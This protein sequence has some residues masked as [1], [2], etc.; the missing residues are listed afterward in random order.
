[1]PGI[2]GIIAKR[3]V[4]SAASLIDKMVKTIARGPASSSGTYL[5]AAT[6]LGIGWA[7][8]K[9][10][11]GDC[12]PAWNG[13]KDL[14][15]FFAGENFADAG[16]IEALGAKGA[17]LRA[18]GAGYLPYLVERR[19]EN[20]AENLNGF[21]SGLVLDVSQN[22][23]VLFNDRYGLGRIY[24]H[25]NADAFFFASEAKALLS[26]LPAIRQLDPTGFSEFLTCGC[27]LQ[28]RTLYKD[29]FLAPPASK[30]TFSKG[31]PVRKETYFRKETW[32]NQG[33]LS[34]AEFY[35][36]LKATWPRIVPKYFI[37]DRPVGMSLTGGLDGRMIMAWAGLKPGSLPCYTFAGSYRDCTDVI[38]ARKVA[39]VCQQSH[40]L[41]PVN[42]DFI[43]RFPT[44]A[45]ES[46]YASDGAM[47]VTGSVELY[48]NKVAREIAPVRMT[49]N[50]G[51]EILR[52]NV[53]FKP[54]KLNSELYDSDLMQRSE[55][56]AKAFRHE[57]E[58]NQL[59]FIAFK[60]VPWHHHSRLAVEQSQ[61]TLRSPYLDNELV[62]LA[63]RT[64]EGLTTSKIPALRI[65]AEGSP[66]LSE[67][68][69]DRG[70]LYRPK[71]LFTK[72]DHMYQEFTFRAEY[73]YD[74]GMPQWLAKIDHAFSPLHLERL[75]LGRHKFFHFR[76]W[77]RDKLGAYLKEM[78]L[79]PKTLSR[80]YVRKGALESMV[81]DHVS[82]TRNYTTE[83]HQMLSCELMQRQLI[84]KNWGKAL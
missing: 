71:P 29:V 18:G 83:L 64:P 78:L 74:Y 73:A 15:V 26:I 42:G 17:G 44:L 41:I 69:T 51:S 21:F 7:L 62:A 34:E 13:K 49:G 43:T 12:L 5:H 79:D 81:R 6:G 8:H 22:K 16:E 37:G 27:A 25:E 45:E 63:F 11:F 68:P 75:F 66:A 36:Q 4:E 70:L 84:E 19:G 33:R 23:L 72:A 61:L 67:I 20:F 82:G 48:V 47:D 2:A 3:P 35:D 65:I 80:P 46:V 39:K 28:N 38:A 56:A 60:Q 54:G 76:V 24:W 52:H 1:M 40:R 59:S 55:A 10:S 58:G 77:Y 30:W 53:A 31:Q 9:G 32:E 50:Y 57:A 14:A